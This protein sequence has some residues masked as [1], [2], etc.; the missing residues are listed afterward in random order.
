ME[1]G[2]AMN[3]G[4]TSPTWWVTTNFPIVLDEWQHVAVTVIRDPP[5][6]TF[7]YNGA[8][9]ETSYKSVSLGN[10]YYTN[11][12][13]GFPRLDIGHGPPSICCTC[14]PMQEYFNGKGEGCRTERRAIPQRPTTLAA[15]TAHQP[16]PH[17]A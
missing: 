6:V 12:S 14:G 7:Y 3:D 17:Q 8:T 13:K 10:L 4:A 2:L 5:T 1:L 15:Q 16:A 11:P 9:I